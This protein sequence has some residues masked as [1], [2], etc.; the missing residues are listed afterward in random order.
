MSQTKK[1]NTVNDHQRANNIVI[2]PQ[3]ENQRLYL[4]ALKNQ[5]QVFALGPAGTGKTFISAVVASELYLRGKVKKIILTRPAVPACGEE[6]GFL[7]GGLNQK[8]APW[9]VPIFEVL[10]DCLG[11]GQLDDAVKNGDVEIAPLGMLRGRTFRDAFVL[12]DEAQNCTKDQLKLILTRM[13]E[14]SRLVVS[15]DLKQ[16]DIKGAS[17]LGMIVEL[18]KKHKLPVGIVEFTKDDVVRSDICKMWVEIFDD[19]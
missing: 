16:S 6:Y 19:E 12:I 14:G 1:R 13:G 8:L 18:A 17:G 5:T 9:V 7:P 15:G 11:K 2:H 4:Q 3:T 10:Q